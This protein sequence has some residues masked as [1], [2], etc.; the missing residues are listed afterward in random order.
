MSFKTDT[1]V[2]HLIGIGILVS[3]DSAQHIFVSYSKN[4]L[5]S[6]DTKNMLNVTMP[7]QIPICSSKL[8][9]QSFT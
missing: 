3:V 7:Y 4:T 6:P 1:T 8:I 5:S 9:L 2:V